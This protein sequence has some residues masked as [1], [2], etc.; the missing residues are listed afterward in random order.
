[1][2]IF[3]E[4]RLVI[5]PVPKTGSTAL[6]NALAPFA[7]LVIRR[8][9]QLRHV[10]VQRYH[11]HVR[12]WLEDAGL[13]GM[14]VV[15][16]MREPESWLA[17]WFRYRQRDNVK[18]TPR[19]TVGVSF[20]DFVRGWCRPKRPACAD[21]GSQERFLRPNQR[22]EWI[23][24]LFRYEELGVFI[25]YL[26]AETGREI[27]LPERNVSPDAP[28]EIAPETRALLRRVA[29]DDY[30]LYEKLTPPRTL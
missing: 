28:L 1:M 29:A 12:P 7:S 24:R 23:D 3:T 25:D 17:S 4:A 30:H 21:V 27:T 8:P 20:D 11:L 10:T 16:V 13:T 6:L 22:G 26:E 2:L 14:R 18:D 5:L 15:A 9:P 19:S